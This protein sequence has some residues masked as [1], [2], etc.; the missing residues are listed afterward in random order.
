MYMMLIYFNHTHFTH[1][2]ELLN[3]YTA[4]VYSSHILYVYILYNIYKYIGIFS[5]I[6]RVQKF[7]LISH[8]AQHLTESFCQL[9]NKLVLYL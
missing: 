5:A 2:A 3:D 7:G 1:S 4:T 9:N 8:I 6:T